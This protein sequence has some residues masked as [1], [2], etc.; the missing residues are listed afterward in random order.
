VSA[1]DAVL[2]VDD[3]ADIREVVGLVL[4]SYGFFAK[5]AADGVEA[6]ARAKEAPHPALILLD[7]MMPN[8]SGADVL[9]ALRADPETARIP[10]VVMSGDV[11]A[12]S[13]ASALGADAC[14]AKPVDLDRLV[15]TV[16][17]FVHPSR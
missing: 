3:D 7:L 8:L 1:A 16:E 12:T 15:S 14:L 4:E 13:Q 17:R 9:V 6:L 2:V 5:S 10:V 11:S